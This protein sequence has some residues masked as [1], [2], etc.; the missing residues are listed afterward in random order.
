MEN[1][2]KRKEYQKKYDKQHY[3]KYSF[4]T[5]FDLSDK[6]EDYCITN[7]IDKTQLFKNAISFYI[8]NDIYNQ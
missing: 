3:K 2:D 4:K 1:N 5:D 6:I 8:M 7:E